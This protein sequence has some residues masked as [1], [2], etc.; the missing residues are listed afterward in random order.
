[1]RRIQTEGGCPLKV[2]VVLGAPGTGKT[3]RGVRV[4]IEALKRGFAPDQ[5]AFVAFT[6]I[7]A[8]TAATRTSAETGIDV[9]DLPYFRTLHSLSFLQLGLSPRDVFSKE[10]LDE[11]GDLVGETLTGDILDPR[12]SGDYL[13]TLDHLSRTTMKSLEETHANAD[14]HDVDWFRLRRF[15]EAYKLYREDRALLDFTDMLSVYAREGSTTP[16]KVAIVDEGQDLTPLQ[17]AVVRRAFANAEELWIMGDDDQSIY[18]WSGADIAHFLALDAEREVLPLSHRLPSEI[19]AVG[20]G[21]IS[22]VERRYGKDVRSERT[23]GV[24]DWVSG[25]EDVDLEGGWLVLARTRHQ[26]RD[27]ASSIRSRGVV[28]SVCG[29]SSV[30]PEHVRSIV[31]YE[32]LRRGDRVDVAEAYSATKAMGIVAELDETRTYTASELG[33]DFSPIWHD[34]LVRIPLDDREYYLACRRNGERLL[35]DPRIRIDTIH[36]AKGAE[37]ERVLLLTDLTYKIRRGFERDPDAEH[38]VFYVG[39]TRASEGLY[40]MAPRTAYGYQI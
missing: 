22:N 18:T 11:F 39:A 8:G 28:Y 23:G 30:D 36:G 29:K 33:Y 32:N 1:M 40:F 3:H 31:A 38:R 12:A 16:V 25:P 35:G 13:M 27:L 26:L 21:I 17:W 2:R 37:A 5:I 19:L 15:A 4:V 34:A 9:K 6:R 20:Q 24:V 7:A 10:D 14:Q